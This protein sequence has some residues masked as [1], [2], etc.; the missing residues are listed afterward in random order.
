MND[1]AR[2][3][4][5]SELQVLARDLDR[6]NEGIRMMEKSLERDRKIAAD[7]MTRIVD[8][9]EALGKPLLTVPA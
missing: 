1:T 8:I 6:L 9:N 4:L 7:T 5:E 3:I 2:A